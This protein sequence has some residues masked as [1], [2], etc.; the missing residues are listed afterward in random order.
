[1]QWRKKHCCG[2]T[3]FVLLL[4][5]LFHAF[6]CTIG[7]TI[8]KYRKIYLRCCSDT[9]IHF[10]FLLCSLCGE[11]LSFGS[12]QKGWVLHKDKRTQIAGTGSARKE[13]EW[14]KEPVAASLVLLCSSLTRF[15]WNKVR[16]DLKSAH[17]WGLCCCFLPAA[18]SSERNEEKNP[19]PALLYCFLEQFCKHGN[20]SLD[21]LC[22]TKALLH[23]GR[24]CVSAW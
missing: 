5:L 24:G 7:G 9:L 11:V 12:K 20:L 17:N 1:M 14:M 10:F 4:R 2:I 8:S 15:N 13:F 6:K 21:L 18:I 23:D 16:G 3:A 19:S 22:H